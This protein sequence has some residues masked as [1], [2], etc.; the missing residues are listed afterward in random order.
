MDS[1]KSHKTTCK[2]MQVVAGKE[3]KDLKIALSHKILSKNNMDLKIFCIKINNRN[4]ESKN[5]HNY[6]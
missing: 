3:S 1:V 6:I 2:I 5:R 4:K